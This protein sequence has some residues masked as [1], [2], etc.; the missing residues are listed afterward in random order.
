MKIN[1]KDKVA[2]FDQKVFNAFRSGDWDIFKELY[3][4]YRKEFLNWAAKYYSIDKEDSTKIYQ[5]SI[6]IFY[7]KVR[8][9]ELTTLNSSIKTYIFGVGKNLI[10]KQFSSNTHV[11]YF[12]EID[13]SIVGNW[14]LRAYEKTEQDHRK[15]ILKQALSKLGE[16]TREIIILFYFHNYSIEAIKNKLGYKSESVVRTTKKKGMDKLKKIIEQLDKD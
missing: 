4:E 8:S 15:Y 13:D 10:K 11:Q 14:D 7:E 5:S 3:H 16:N 1:H 12:E 2:S 9:G 6:V